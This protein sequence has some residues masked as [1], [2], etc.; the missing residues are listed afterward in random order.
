MRNESQEQ[1]PGKYRHFKVWTEI[2]ESVK[3]IREDMKIKKKIV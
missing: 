3:E 2:E 1:N